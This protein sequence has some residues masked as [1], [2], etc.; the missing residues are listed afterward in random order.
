MSIVLSPLKASNIVFDFIAI[1]LRIRKCRW[2]KTIPRLD[3]FVLDDVINS[4]TKFEVILISQDS[5]K[6]WN[7]NL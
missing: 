7:L 4:K 2:I 3:I 1:N 6:R 5:I